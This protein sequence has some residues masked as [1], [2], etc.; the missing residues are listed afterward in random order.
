MNKQKNILRVLICVVILLCIGVN[1]AKAYDFSSA[2]STGVTIY[3]T[4]TST[5]EYTAEVAPSPDVSYSGNLVIPS[6]VSYNG[7]T[8]SITSIGERAFAE[9]D[10]LLSVT[11]P[12]TIKTIKAEA[13]S[14]CTGLT[15]LVIPNSVTNIYNNAF[16]YCVLLQ[17]VTIPSSVTVLGGNVFY[18][19]WGLISVVLPNNMEYI[20]S[21]AFANCNNLKEINMPDSL[22]AIDGFAFYNCS[23]LQSLILPS[24]LHGIGF[25]SFAY[26]SGL[27]FLICKASVPPSIDEED[28][29]KEDVSTIPFYVPCS[30]LSVYSNENDWNYFTNYRGF[31]S[32]TLITAQIATGTTYTLNG[33]N[34][35]T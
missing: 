32:D 8:Y 10:N 5:S 9:Y 17:S 23:S 15:S 14:Y 21:Y 29:F 18:N 2:N 27:N 22:E 31:S 33:F 20:S 3:Y 25:Q 1:T 16:E 24:T 35:D 30:S 7:N 4:I 19:C 6:T 13:F 12:N 11:M 26:C 34:A 28:S